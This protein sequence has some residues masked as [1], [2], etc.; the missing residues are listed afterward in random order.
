MDAAS[1]KCLVA[2]IVDV[3]PGVGA[4]IRA[5][6]A[7]AL[8]PCHLAATKADLPD[9]RAV[10]FLGHTA[11]GYAVV[12]P[13]I[14]EIPKRAF[15][16]ERGLLRVVVPDSVMRI[17]ASAFAGTSLQQLTIPNCV[18]KVDQNILAACDSL[19][20]VSLPGHM[21]GTRLDPDRLQGSR[22]PAAAVLGIENNAVAIHYRTQYSRRNKTI[23]NESAGIS[24]EAYQ[25]RFAKMMARHNSE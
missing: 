20:T 6:V 24:S 7:C 13:D 25:R 11:K 23:H 8:V 16:A 14:D 1:L 4:I 9:D 5:L 3:E 10:N 12:V 17:G 22:K 15:Y 2:R 21:R 19:E 18:S